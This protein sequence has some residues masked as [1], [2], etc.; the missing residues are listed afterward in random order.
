MVRLILVAVKEIGWM[1]LRAML[2]LVMMVIPTMYFPISK[3][4]Y[5]VGMV[6][7]P[8]WL[9]PDRIAVEIAGPDRRVAFQ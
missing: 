1:L 8:F 6:A 7:L 9:I 3:E 2:L 5:Q 4:F